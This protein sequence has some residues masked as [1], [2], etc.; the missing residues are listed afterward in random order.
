MTYFSLLLRIML[1]VSISLNGYAA[2]AITVGGAHAM[3]RAH[4]VAA[5]SSDAASSESAMTAECHEG[6]T[7]GIDHAAMNHDGM[8]RAGMHHAA[9]NHSAEAATAQS[10]DATLSAQPDDCCG[11]FRCQCDCTHAVA[12]VR[13]ALRLAPALAGPALALPPEAAAPNGVSSLPI[14]PPIA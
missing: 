8:N 10:A 1:I 6:M 7:A 3:H 11:G 12:I 2:A 9:M 14:R 4:A 13:V 5:A